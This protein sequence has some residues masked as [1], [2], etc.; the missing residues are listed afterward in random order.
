MPNLKK[1]VNLSFL[2][3]GILAGFL[4]REAC[5]TLYDWV[6]WRPIDWVLSQ[7][8]LSGIAAGAALFIGLA[9]STKATG[10]LSD[11]F[12]ELSKVTWPKR[13][14]TL[15]STGVV[16]I[17]LG[18]AAICVMLFDAVWVWVTDTFLY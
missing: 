17:L 8:D 10:F 3:T 14:E 15:V 9:R 6:G 16:S 4:F 12:V 5:T 11:V 7:A 1:W 13:K 18:I 2:L